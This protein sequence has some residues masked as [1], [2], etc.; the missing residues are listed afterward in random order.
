MET[1]DSATAARIDEIFGR[2]P[3]YENDPERQDLLWADLAAGPLAD[4]ALPYDLHWQTYERVFR[5]RPATVPPPRVWRPAVERVRTS[6]LAALMREVGA[7]DYAALHAWSVQNRAA[8][9]EATIRQLGIPFVTPP[10]AILDESSSV[11]EVRWLPG[12]R[13]N[14]SDACFRAPAEKTAIIA[15]GEG[16][17][18]LRRMTYGELEELAGRFARGL[19]N[20]GLEPG[21]AVALYMPM[22]VECVAAYLGIVRAGMTVVS[23]P[24][25]FAPPEVAT[26]LRLGGAST[27]LT[28]DAFQ[29]GGKRVS[30]YSK[31]VEAG[32]RRLIVIGE[33]A[34]LRHGDLS[35]SEFLGDSSAPSVAREPYDTTNILFSS[36]TTGEPK[37]IPWNHLTPIKSAMDGCYHQDIHVE[38]VVAWPTNIGWMMGPWLIYASLVNG[39]TMALYEGVPTT[40]GFTRF[41]RDSGITILGLVPAIVRAWRESGAVAGDELANVRVLSSTGEASNVFDYLWLMSRTRYRAPIIEYCGGTE[42]GGGHITG[43]VVQP[44]SPATFTTPALG[45]DFAI[46]DEEGRP[47][48]EG[49]HGEIFLVPPSIGISQRLL[50]RDH[51]EEY[52]AGCPK[53]PRGK[54]LRRH[55]DEVQR[56]PGD[57]YRA[58]GRA[59][60]TMNL[61]GIKVGSVELETVL[62]GHPRISETAAVAVP[63]EGGGADRLVV[64]AVLTEP[65]D[66]R[67]LKAELQGRLKERSNP[68]FRIHDLVVVDALPRTPSNK[69]MRRELRGRYEAR[70]TTERTS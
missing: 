21:D 59:D 5:G 60:D 52:Y 23:I 6:N 70:A 24:D 50:N 26:R 68:L 11:E 27:M 17:V 29:R 57:F 53:G 48:E 32:A 54:Q 49:Q 47:V 18:G 65:G 45:L 15:G 35:W 14:A 37:A 61:G 3:G 22:T 64:F 33:S 2:Y 42:I 62:N 31:A 46:L 7:A 55:G 43:T 19:M 36:G 28:V 51:H 40:A 34:E 30:M 12:A 38:D 16:D 10:A 67:T 25:S 63:P 20:H 8:F 41:V 66:P 44:A 4:L 9:W 1:T 69:V 58:M 39:A 13:L 56:L